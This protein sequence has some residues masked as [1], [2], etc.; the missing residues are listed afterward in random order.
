MCTYS[1]MCVS[2]NKSMYNAIAGKKAATGIQTSNGFNW[3]KGSDMS[4]YPKPGTRNGLTQIEHA[5]T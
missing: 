5:F 3:P 4:R 1:Q 2:T